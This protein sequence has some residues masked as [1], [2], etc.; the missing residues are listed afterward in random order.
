MFECCTV[1]T[2]HRFP[3][4]PRRKPTYIYQDVSSACR[5]WMLAVAVVAAASPPLPSHAELL[6]RLACEPE[7]TARS[8][9]DAGTGQVVALK[10]GGREV[11]LDRADGTPQE[12]RV[13]PGGPSAVL[14]AYG[15]RD[16]QNVPHGTS[17]LWQVPCTARPPKA[18]V[19]VDGADFGHSALAPDTRTLFFTG[20]DG[21]LA[22][23]LATRAIRR[24]THAALPYCRK[25]EIDTRDVVGA[26]VDGR[27]LS[28]ER[29]CSYQ[30]EWHVQSMLLEHPGTPKMVTSRA[31]R[32]PFASV[33]VDARG[34]V[35]LSD[36]IC[37]EPSTFGRV[38][39]SADQ[40]E[41]WEKVAIK[42]IGSHPVRQVVADSRNPDVLLVF[43]FACG[44]PQHVDPGW[45][46]I[47]RDAGK[48]FRP[49]AVPKGIPAGANG[50]P[51]DE[52]DPIRAVIVPDGRVDHLIT[53]GESSFVAGDQIARWES[54]DGGK[55]WTTLPPVIKPPIP[56]APVGPGVKLDYRI[57][58]EGLYRHEKGK[59]PVR[60]YPRS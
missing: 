28:F 11:N 38:L 25:N 20:P 31:P 3:E 6:P 26:F 8:F 9:P 50:Y 22:I 48:T 57:R 41:H 32:P 52:Q 4:E 13:Y 42:E 24:V 14:V 35:W 1:E 17:T 55:T 30:W 46:F 39:H 34:G 10:V 60:V 51:S 12:L 15:G 45:V 18:F 47:S 43:T 19:H 7:L 29:G 37:E 21:I 16:S 59:A 23:D 58:S 5:P 56:A 49:V 53:F 40:G 54:R 33:A 44:S 27:T 36:G 2:A